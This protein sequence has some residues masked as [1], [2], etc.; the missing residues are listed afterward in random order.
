MRR[1]C[2]APGQQTARIAAA[3]LCLLLLASGCQGG[4]GA[5][6]AAFVKQANAL[7]GQ[8]ATDYTAAKAAMPAAPSRE[9][10]KTMVQGTFAPEAIQTY[11]RIQGLP[12]PS[13]DADDLRSLLTSAIAEVKLIQL[14][15]ATFGNQQNQ[16]DLV[17][18][19]ADYGLTDCG[20]GFA[21]DIDKAEWIREVNDLCTAFG[22][23]Q[24][25]TLVGRDVSPASSPEVIA[26]FVRD[27][28]APLSDDVVAQIRALGFPQG[29]EQPLEQLLQAVHADV[30][31][32]LATPS[33]YFDTSRPSLVDLV[34]Q[35]RTYG[36]TA[37]GA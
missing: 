6:K 8:L 5:S 30:Q 37:C 33:L 22:A 31:L 35:W 29:D 18:R 19:F 20:A 2:V 17:K 36:V 26:A 3:L 7:C 21:R 27:V 25:A 1:P 9:D 16:R 24:Q 11:T 10:T 13:S 15:P 4:G 23:K 12:L 34:Q 14:D 28:A 32:V